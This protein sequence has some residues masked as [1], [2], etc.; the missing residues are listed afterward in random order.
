MASGNVSIMFVPFASTPVCSSRKVEIINAN[1]LISSVFILFIVQCLSRLDF[2][3]LSGRE[4]DADDNHQC[5]QKIR[6]Q[7]SDGKPSC[8]KFR[9]QSGI[10]NIQIQDSGYDGGSSEEYQSLG[11]F[12]YKHIP[13]TAAQC[14]HQSYLAL[15]LLR[16]EPEGAQYADE[17]IEHQKRSAD[18]I[19]S[20]VV[21]LRTLIVGTDILE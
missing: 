8:L 10:S 14:L 20:H 4:P 13:A 1:F 5:C 18:H 17:D 6:Y 2:H 21:H 15:A 16:A 19:I 9:A 7:Y 11:D 3:R 12:P